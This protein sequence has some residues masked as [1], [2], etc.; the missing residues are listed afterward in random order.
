MATTKRLGAT[1]CLVKKDA[2]WIQLVVES[3]VEAIIAAGGK[4]IHVLKKEKKLLTHLK[5][6]FTHVQ[7]R[8]PILVRSSKK[9]SS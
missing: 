7:R 2:T 1:V 8:M 5:P 4:I 3:N 9:P 6:G